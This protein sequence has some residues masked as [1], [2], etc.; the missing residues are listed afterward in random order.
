MLLLETGAK[1]SNW[2][3]EMCEMNMK[4]KQQQQHTQKFTKQKSHIS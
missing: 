1:H 3:D 2:N 4:E